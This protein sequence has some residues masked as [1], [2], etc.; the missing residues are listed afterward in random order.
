[1]L[2]STHTQYTQNKQYKDLSASCWLSTRKFIWFFIHRGKTFALH[3][4]YG[5]GVYHH[6]RYSTELRSYDLIIL[7]ETNASASPS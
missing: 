2:Y 4:T 1:M 3:R 7:R 5:M 6:F